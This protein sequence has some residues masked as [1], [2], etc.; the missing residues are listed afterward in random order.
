MWDDMPRLEGWSYSEGR[1][2]VALRSAGYTAAHLKSYGDEPGAPE[3]I[4]ANRETPVKYLKGMKGCSSKKVT[5]LTAQLKCL[6]TNAHS[7]GN[8]QE[9]LEATML[10][11][12]YELVAI[13]ET[14]WDKSHDWRAPINGHRLFRRN[15]G[16][17]RG[18]GVA[19]YIKKWIEY[20]RAV[21]EE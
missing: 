3:V 7:M 21:P 18:G 14:S 4:G 6:Y 5:R 11:E 19:L 1:Q 20:E 15:R 10:L 13:T 16:G 2:L 9:E 8:K 17:R 12:S